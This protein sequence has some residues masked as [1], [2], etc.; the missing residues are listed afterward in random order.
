MATSLC[1]ALEQHGISTICKKNI[2]CGITIMNSNPPAFLLI[3][4]DMDN[5]WSF[6]EDVMRKHYNPTPY[7]LIVAT[8]SDDI[9]RTSLLNY[10]ADACIE[11]PADAEEVLAIINAV[12]RRERRLRLP[13]I[14]GL[15][16]CIEY[17]KLLIDP[18]RRTVSVHGQ[19]V[20]LTPKEFDL[21][22]LL[23]S[24]PGIVFSKQEI[25]AHIWKAEYTFATTSVYDHISSLRQKLDIYPHEE[26]YIQTIFG[27]GYR[28]FET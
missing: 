9:N 27:V 8:L 21:L 13:H 20:K 2:F 14:S 16:P 22:Y 25:Y 7:V 24:H 28:F 4:L 1:A 3:D 17:N 6:W 10:G 26:E 12:F 19:S 23:A 18:L 5:A 15:L 11:K